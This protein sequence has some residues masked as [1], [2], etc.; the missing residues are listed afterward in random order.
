VDSRELIEELERRDETI[1]AALSGVQQLA[2]RTGELRAD[3]ARVAAFLAALPAERERRAEAAAAAAERLDRAHVELARAEQERSRAEER[4]KERERAAAAR[5]AAEAAQQLHVATHELDRAR[6]AAAALEDEAEAAAARRESLEAEA[7]AAAVE[8]RSV[9]RLA[10]EAARTPAPGLDGV[11]AWGAQARAAL[12]V[13]RASLAAERDAVVRE[14]NELGSAL[15]GEPLGAT[16][17][18]RVRER[19]ESR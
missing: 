1:A 11:E 18:A 13:V 7:A 15:L 2:R 5:A 4:G 10:P 14:A 8:L 17:V 16:S 3:A 12:L 6:E 9:P 19:V